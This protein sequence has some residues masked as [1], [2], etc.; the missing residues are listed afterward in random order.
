MG[1]RSLRQI[2]GNTVVGL[3]ALLLLQGCGLKGDL[4]LEG[5]KGG[6]ATF[7]EQE[8]EEFL[9]DSLEEQSEDIAAGEESSFDDENDRILDD[10]AEETL[11][12]EET[13]NSIED[14]PDAPPAAEDDQAIP[15]ESSLD[16]PAE[17]IEG[18]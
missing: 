12:D 4:Y 17:M 10:S 9:Q 8:N 15:E 14:S 11:L 7:K 1:T 13:E 3:V 18:Q 6:A 16:E 5:D 2:F